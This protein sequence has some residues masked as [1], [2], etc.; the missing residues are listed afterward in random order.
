MTAALIV[1]VE[2]DDP[3]GLP[4]MADDMYDTLNSS[5]YA[6]VDVKPYAR[7]TLPDQPM[8]PGFTPPPPPLV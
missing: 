5:G 2:I 4:D 1:T 6:V 3:M 8:L 7:P